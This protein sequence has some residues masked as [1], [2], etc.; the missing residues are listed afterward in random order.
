MIVLG[1]NAEWIN[2][3]CREGLI[4]PG[5]VRGLNSDWLDED[6]NRMKL[7]LD[8]GVLKDFKHGQKYNVLYCRSEPNVE[9][10]A[11]ATQ[12]VEE[13]RDRMLKWMLGRG[14]EADLVI[15]DVRPVMRYRTVATTVH[16]DEP[17]SFQALL[18]L[19]SSRKVRTLYI[20]SIDRFQIGGWMMVEDLAKMCGAEI[21]VMNRI[22][23]TEEMKAEAKYWMADLL[24][25]YKVMSG[26][27]RSQNITDMFLKGYDPKLT[28]RMVQ[29]VAAKMAQ[30]VKTK[31]LR[32]KKWLTVPYDRR[33]VD[34]EECWDETDIWKARKDLGLGS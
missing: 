29:R 8:Y 21:V 16:E 32:S 13:Q 24:T 30:V 15:R 18:G 7:I 23:P 33:I 27:L 22:Y 14:Y 25:Y 10:L 31:R 4:L 12:R 26:E 3:R 19:I 2:A 20:E 6:I 34:L 28:V 11:P 1:K 17:V 9:G 5:I